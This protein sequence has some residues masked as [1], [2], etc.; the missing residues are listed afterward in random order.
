MTSESSPEL[1]RAVALAWGVAANPQRGPKR[2]MS[3]ERI[4]DAA[5]ELADAGGLGAV[6]MAAVASALGFTPMSLY[7]YVTAKDDLC[8]SCRS[9]G[10]G[11][12]PEA[13]LESGAV[14]RRARCAGRGDTVELYT[15]APVA[16]RHPD[17]GTPR[18]RTTSPGSRPRCRCSSRCRS[19]PN[20]KISIV[21]AI[22]RSHAGRDIVIRGYVEAAAA[23]GSTT[24]DLE[25]AA[26]GA[27]SSSSS[28]PRS[29]RSSTPRSTPACSRPSRGRRRPVR[30]RPRAGAR[31]RRGATS[32]GTRDQGRRR[33]AR[34][35]LADAV[36]HDPKVKEAVKARR[37]VEKK[38]REARKREREMER[39]ARERL[40]RQK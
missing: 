10:I 40:A 11:V 13:I 37:E 12:P 17:R 14:A 23:A 2:E 3:V 4:V 6:S 26:I 30:L 29:S 1:P 34:D 9:A 39:N 28:R 27:S 31:R 35:P 15:R 22:M 20:D 36:A 16:A 5:V 24:D 18:R 8:C 19:T 33:A 25:L 21:L 38:L 32:R 7:R